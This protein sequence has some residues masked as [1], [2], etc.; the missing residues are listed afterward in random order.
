VGA[1]A[2]G[3][4]PNVGALSGALRTAGDVGVGETT[5]VLV[6]LNPG[7]RPDMTPI[8][9]TKAAKTKKMPTTGSTTLLNTATT[10]AIATT[11]NAS[12]TSCVIMQTP[13]THFLNLPSV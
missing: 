1:L 13:L 5:V 10:T 12:K 11:A 7:N 3:V 6:V 4:F 2:E 8:P 9:K